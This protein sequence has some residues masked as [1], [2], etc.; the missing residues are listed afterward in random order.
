M[1][2][3]PGELRVAQCGHLE[4][5]GNVG[6]LRGNQRPRKQ[7][8]PLRIQERVG[9]SNGA[10]VYATESIPWNFDRAW[11]IGFKQLGPG[12]R[13]VEGIKATHAGIVRGGAN[14]QVVPAGIIG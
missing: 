2:I 6:S 13:A 8:E 10:K 14:S 4:C 9:K 12:E 7:R 3:R 5:A 1:E 11:R